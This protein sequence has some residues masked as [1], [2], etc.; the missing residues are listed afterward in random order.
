[1][2]NNCPLCGRELIS[3]PSVDKHHLVPKSLGGKDVILLHKICHRKIH[4]I[5]TEKELKKEYNSIAKLLN[6]AE[7]IKFINWVKK[8]PANFMDKNITANRKRR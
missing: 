7:I 4:S 6:H 8:K 1:M 3:G 5:F 2:N